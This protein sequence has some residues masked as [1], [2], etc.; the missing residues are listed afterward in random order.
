MDCPGLCLTDVQVAGRKGFGHPPDHTNGDEQKG[1]EELEYMS[2]EQEAAQ[3]IAEGLDGW[4][5]EVEYI[6][7]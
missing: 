3:G 1:W 6:S 7:W 4:R 5:S 2:T